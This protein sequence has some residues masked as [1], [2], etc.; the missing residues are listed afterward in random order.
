MIEE[1]TWLNAYAKS[2][3]A[4]KPVYYYTVYCIQAVDEIL[5]GLKDGLSW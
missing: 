1:H 2:N 5:H 3:K 4:Y